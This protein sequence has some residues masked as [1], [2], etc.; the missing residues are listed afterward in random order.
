MQEPV[1][2]LVKPGEKVQLKSGQAYELILV[3]PMAV[4]DGHSH[5][6]SGATCPLPL[7]WSQNLATAFLHPSRATA[8]VIAPTV[9][10][11]MGKKGGSVQSK[12][13]EAIAG[14]LVEEHKKAYGPESKLR[15]AE[16]YKHAQEFFSP[17]IIMPMDMDYAHIAGFPPTSTM[18][19][20]EGKFQKWTPTGPNMPALLVTVDGVFYYDRQDALAPEENGVIYDLTS[21]RPNRAWVYQ[22]YYRQHLSTIEAVKQ[23]P[24]LLIPMFHFDPRRWRNPSAGQ[25]DDENWYFGPWDTP[26]KY[27]ATLRNA[28]IFIGFK[29]YPPL[30]YKPLDSRLPHLLDFYKRCVDEDIPVLT[31]CSPGGMTTHEARFYH[32][33]DKVELKPGP[34]VDAVT[35]GATRRLGYDP[36]TPEGYFFD[37]Y[38]HPKN[39]RKVL[40]KFPKLRLCLAHLGGDEWKNVGIESDWIQEIIKLTKEYPNVYTDM[41]CYDLEDSKT[42]ENVTVLLREMRDNNQ[43]QH[44]KDKVI[45]GVDWYLS[46]LTGAPKYKEYVESFFETMGEIDKSQWLRSALVNPAAFY[47]LDK[48]DKLDNMQAALLTITKSSNSE[49]KEMLRT[50]YKNALRIKDQIA[51]VRAKIGKV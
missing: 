3:E 21:E 28:G 44:L 27:V 39:W 9:L 8:N 4:I 17:S 40:E 5:I 24:W 48:K 46:L 26:F 51:S 19:Y 23:N 31:H 29:M 7:I 35:G 41:S 43:Y 20:H 36:S 13:T 14:V 25:I 50:N 11:T 37:E 47:G 2:I 32:K 16:L 42:R 10:W 33:L 45:F 6:Q 18:I 12:S 38:V 15:K 49:V 22:M 1:R 30:G 34:K